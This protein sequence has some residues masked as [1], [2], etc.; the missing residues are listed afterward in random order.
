M[1]T[2]E[3]TAKVA[4]PTDYLSAVTTDKKYEIVDVGARAGVLDNRD[5]IDEISGMIQG[6]V[7][8]L[9]KTDIALSDGSTTN[10]ITIGGE[11]VT[12]VDGDMVSYSPGEGEND[13]EFIWGSNRWN[14]FGS[15]GALKALAFKDSAS[16]TYT[17]SGSVSLTTADKTASL[18]GGAA[19]FSEISV[20]A[21]LVMDNYTPAGTI[22]IELAAPA[23]GA[24]SA[25]EITPTGSVT[26]TEISSATF[27]GNALTATGSFTGSAATINA[28]ATLP[29]L[30]TLNVT[31]P[32][33][34]VTA[35]TTTVL[36]TATVS[37]G[38]LSFGTTAAVASVSATATGGN[39]EY[40]TTYDRAL[41][42]TAEYTPAG[43]VSV[44]PGTPSGTIS[45]G[46]KT[47]DKT[48]SINAFT[49]QG[50]VAV[51]APTVTTKT[52]TGTAA[53]PTGHVDTTKFTPAAT[54]VTGTVT[55]TDVPT[56][57][58]FSGTTATITVS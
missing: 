19:E 26:V 11:S 29:E 50:S 3:L 39:T 56:G 37:E 42:A 58:N 14:E 13:L 34:N 49:P 32:T 51:A 20:Q 12:A 35:P 24:L 38:V 57:A 22:D 1:T 36:D 17:P 25:D 6:G 54:S 9:G 46:E 16:G 30:P 7:H 33:V 31:Q 43:S 41:T 2:N 40:A 44:T 4:L 8:Y 18:T 55:I 45:L 28:T 21:A 10:P 27:S 23:A 5:L 52:F 53:A 47:A 15:T 48:L